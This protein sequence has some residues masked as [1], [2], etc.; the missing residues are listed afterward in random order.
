MPVVIT[1]SVKKSEDR[2]V[3]EAFPEHPSIAPVEPLHKVTVLPLLP[4]FKTCASV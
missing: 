3:G 4:V 2:T 1:R